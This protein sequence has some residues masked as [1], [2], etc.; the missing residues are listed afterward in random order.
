MSDNFYRAFEE[1]HRGTRDLI[2]LRQR[3]YLPFI[4]PIQSIYNDAKEIGRAHV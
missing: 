4:E 3:V 2:K 1:K